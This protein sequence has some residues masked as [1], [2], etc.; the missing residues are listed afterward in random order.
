MMKKIY[1]TLLATAFF[2]GMST[3][4][5]A[6]SDM[7]KVQHPAS[8][9]KSTVESMEKSQILEAPAQE[10]GQAKGETPEAYSEPD[11]DTGAKAEAVMDEK[12]EELE[13]KEAK[14]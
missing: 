11:K 1:V 14:E 2:A 7:E 6:G 13:Q 10:A 12:A 3:L 5:M 9:E 8:A 4:A